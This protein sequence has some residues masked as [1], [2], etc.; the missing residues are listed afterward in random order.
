MDGLPGLRRGLAA[1]KREKV[2]PIQKMVGPL[3]PTAYRNGQG[4]SVAQV[5]II[6]FLSLVAGILMATYA[7]D[8]REAASN[9]ES[10]VLHSFMSPGK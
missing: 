8:L 4:F 9:W 5:I 1:G 2:A 3:A 7:S 10:G 6:A